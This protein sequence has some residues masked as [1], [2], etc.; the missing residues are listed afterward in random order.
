MIALQDRYLGCLIGLACG[1]ALGAPVE[2]ESRSALD[3]RFPDGLR[4]FIGGGWLD[5]EPGEITDDTQMTLDVAR[6]L[7][8]LPDGDMDDLAARFLAWRNS[9]PKD[10]GNTTR[11]ALDRLAGGV[12]WQDAGAQTVES[13]GPVDSAG[14]GAIMRCA[15]V[16]LRFRNDPCRLRDVSIDVARITHA[17]PLCTWASVAVDQ[18]IAALLHGESIPAALELASTGIANDDVREAITLASIGVRDDISSNGFVLDTLTAAFWALRHTD[19]FEEAVV[20]AVG[21]GGDTDTTGAVAGSLGGARYGIDA[22]PDRWR[23]QV[24]YREE[25]A[26]LAHSLLELSAA[27]VS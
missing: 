8:A 2:F 23:Q 18:A 15:P 21:L 16:A 7:V 11:D 25:L 20:M 1:D 22:I 9:D 6:S 14:N 13:R 5:L 26:A 27:G 24:Q 17:N 12:S 19:S 4:A 3:E 10:I